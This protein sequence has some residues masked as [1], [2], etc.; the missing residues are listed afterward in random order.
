MPAENSK[1]P[2]FL[3]PLVIV[4]TA[5]ILFQGYRLRRLQQEN[6]HRPGPGAQQRKG[7]SEACQ[8][9]THPRIMT[10]RSEA[11]IFY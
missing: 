2:G 7:D 11:L 9:N 8:Q 5:V 1:R 10:G 4:L 3:I 6:V